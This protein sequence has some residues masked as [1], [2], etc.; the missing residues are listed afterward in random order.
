MLQFDDKSLIV[1]K[2]K[3]YC[4]QS[5]LDPTVIPTFKSIPNEELEK[6]LIGYEEILSVAGFFSNQ[7]LDSIEGKEI[8][9]LIGIS[10]EDGVILHIDGDQSIRDMMNE[11][12]FNVGLQFLE[13]YAG[14]N[15][16]NLALKYQSPIELIGN[17]HYHHFFHNAACYAVPFYSKKGGNL[18]GTISI[19]TLVEYEH[20]FF[21]AM[22]ITM[23]ESIERE[24]ILRIQNN[25]LDVLNHIVIDTTS[26]AIVATD[27]DGIITEFNKFA[28]KIT[29]FRKEEVIGQSITCLSNINTYIDQ[30]ITEEKK[31]EDIQLLFCDSESNLKIVCL[32]DA[33]PIYDKKGKLIGALGQFRDITERYETEKKI[34]Y[35]AHHDEVT[36]LPN[37]RLFKKQFLHEIEAV[38]HLNEKLAIIFIDLDRFKYVNDTFGH[39]EGDRLLQ[40]VSERLKSC[41]CLGRD[42]VAR[43]GG[44]EFIFIVPQKN[45]RESIHNYALDILS[46]L[47][48]PFV[49]NGFDLH[50]SASLG[51]AIFPDDGQDLETLL[52]YADSA[53]YKAKL[54]GG[55][56][57][58]IFKPGMYSSSH[59]KLLLENA[60]RNSI[61]NR[62]LIL[63]YQ[64]QVDAKTGQLIGVEA[65]VRWK[66][67]E[68][69]IVSPEEFIPLSEETGFIIPLGEWVLREACFQ[70]KRWQ[71]AG[72]AP[73]KISVNLSGKQF[74]QDQLADEVNRILKETGL[75]PEFLDLE[76]TESMM[77]DVNHAIYILNELHTL[78]IQISIDDFGTGYSSLNYLKRFS[79]NRL[80]IDRSFVD[81]I[82][83]DSSDA[84]IV[85]TIIAMAHNLGLSVIAEGVESKEQLEFLVSKN[86]DEYQ[87][88]LCSKPISAEEFENEFLKNN[89]LKSIS[90]I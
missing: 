64:P 9:L 25:K 35:M 28:E 58:Q 30:V 73:I 57:F 39:T 69:G 80:K 90:S 26:N 86:C 16:V 88:F 60:L 67:P 42:M 75:A 53:M 54:N 44:D 71:E 45:I 68:L 36:G 87:G 76:I 20:P 21:L 65:L 3:Q 56:N 5:G 55:N 33:L 29:N 63:N 66:H 27:A 19:M 2:S 43:M 50:I 18:L 8:P 52:V 12:G 24:L 11:L 14:T 10:N 41:L 1:Q 51:I 48:E 32:F 7:F 59:K 47:D 83:N 46:R 84:S 79:I 49:M 62:E 37:R 31:F 15:V 23:V 40:Q 70:N 78:G 17:D 74:S 6:I 61:K 82:M 72:Y 38:R 81:D 89:N 34:N 4:K 85:E 22:L 13:A 77:M